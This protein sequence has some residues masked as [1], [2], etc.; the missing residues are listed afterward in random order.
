[1]KFIKRFT[2]IDRDYTVLIK[3]ENLACFSNMHI[4]RGLERMYRFRYRKYYLLFCD[5]VSPDK[6]QQNY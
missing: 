4:P 3:N 5:F 6:L 2:N 1:M